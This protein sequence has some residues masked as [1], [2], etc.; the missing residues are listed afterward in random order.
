MSGARRI[1]NLP[2]H[3]GERESCRA[4]QIEMEK[5][6]AK[7]TR[8]GVALAYAETGRGAPPI[9]L[10]HGLACDHSQFG[11]QIAHFGRDHRV[12]AIDFRGHGES[13]KPHQDYT[14]GLYADD[15]AWLC[16]E[17]GVYKPVIIGHSLG[18]T[19]AVELAAR[20]PDL[21]AAIVLLDS[22][23]VFPPGTTE[24]LQ[25]FTEG[26]RTPA[27]LDVLRQFM[28]MAFLPTDDQERKARI[29]D[30]MGA[31]P[32]QVVR[33]TWVNTFLTDTDASAAKVKVPVL[34][35]DAVAPNCDLARFQSLTPQLVTG[36]TVGAGHW[37]QLEVPEQV[38]AMVDRFL[39][40]ALRDPPEAT[41]W[42]KPE[43][44]GNGPRA[45]ESPRGGGRGRRGR[46]RPSPRPW[47]RRGGAR[48]GRAG[49]D[50]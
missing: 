4:D 30:A 22:P 2:S 42:F 13:D 7:L 33:S 16:N 3:G 39:T 24:F 14:L 38:N 25:P 29:L 28:S 48:R 5:T 31:V 50:L 23:V 10:A 37:P 1:G 17:L 45:G 36:K 11:P 9:L 15:L 27:Y 49:R 8:D 12:I 26:L 35:L 41:T 47:A 40:I 43:T 18:G 19:V 32:Q 20:Y 44:W 6:M 21:P 34:Y 46:G